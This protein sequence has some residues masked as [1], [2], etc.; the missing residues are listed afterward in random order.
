MHV[1]C[2]LELDNHGTSQFPHF[3]DQLLS[4]RQYF[5]LLLVAAAASL[6]QIVV[7][8]YFI[9]LSSKWLTTARGV[10]TTD[11]VPYIVIAMPTGDMVATIEYGIAFT[12]YLVAYAAIVYYG[13][14]TWAHMRRVMALAGPGAGVAATQRRD[15]AQ[16]QLTAVLVTQALGPLLLNVL[17]GIYTTVQNGIDPAQSATAD[18]VFAPTA[19]LTVSSNWVPVLGGVLALAII[20][21]YREALLSWCRRLVPFC[22]GGT[23]NTQSGGVGMVT[24]VVTSSSAPIAPIS[25][26]H[27]A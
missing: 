25:V 22:G 4:L 16:R 7:D 5:G 3:S 23:V 18:A 1:S 10:F 11:E 2:S 24:V 14:R 17:P 9:D 6:S 12:I 20:R 15:A 26:A 19:L 8:I 21:P 27:V 13:V